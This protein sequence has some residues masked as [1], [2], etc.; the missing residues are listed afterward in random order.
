MRLRS[1]FT[2]FTAISLIWFF[3]LA[4]ADTFDVLMGVST[5]CNGITA[6]LA[7]AAMLMVLVAAVVY[8]AGQIM[9]AETRARANVWATVCIT[10]AMIG[11]L[12]SS[13]GPP[14]L[15]LV[16]GDQVSCTTQA[17]MC[18]STALQPGEK[19]CAPK[20]AAK[21]YD[22]TL[23][24]CCESL[25]QKVGSTWLV[26]Y[27]NTVACCSYADYPNTV[28]NCQ[29]PRPYCVDGSPWCKA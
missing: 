10:G 16:Y 2:F 17:L 27:A 5:L 12:I 6:L 19:C 24:I 11:V 26:A 1:I 21:S 29:A 15:Q 4:F 7:P 28:W 3:G 20:G 18:G 9:G 22:P 8:A 13:V 14:V 25:D 23:R